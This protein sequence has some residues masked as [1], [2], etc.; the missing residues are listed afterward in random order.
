[1][2]VYAQFFVLSTGYV[3]GSVPPQFKKELR[4]PIEKCGSDGVHIL[5]GRKNIHNLVLDARQQLKR[6]TQNKQPNFIVGFQIV[7]GTSFTNGRVAYS[8][9]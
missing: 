7:R 9:I 2:K 1:M 3:E 5:D 4:R 6:I 8:N